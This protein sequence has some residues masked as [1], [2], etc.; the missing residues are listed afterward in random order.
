VNKEFK[1]IRHDLMLNEYPQEFVDSI[2]KP[3]RS[4]SHS[5]DTVYQD[6]VIS[7]YVKGICEIFRRIGNCFNVRTV[8]K[9]N[10]YSMGH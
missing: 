3:L 7:P 4:K 9:L 1:S 5:S 8:S 2:M 10:M 6:M